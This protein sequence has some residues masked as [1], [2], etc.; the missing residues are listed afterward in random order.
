VE[1]LIPQTRELGGR[2]TVPAIPV[3]MTTTKTGA[4]SVTFHV[5]FENA[6]EAFLAL[7]KSQSKSVMLSVTPEEA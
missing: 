4:L 1:R 6:D 7:R 2:V 5:P 3:G